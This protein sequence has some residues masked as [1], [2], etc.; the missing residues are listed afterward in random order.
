MEGRKLILD[1]LEVAKPP[2]SDQPRPMVNGGQ[3][4]VTK[5]IHDNALVVPQEAIER[6][7]NSG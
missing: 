1:G 7:S 6:W 4:E 2:A 3:L 5:L